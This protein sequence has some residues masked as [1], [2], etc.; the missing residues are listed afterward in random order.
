MESVEG[1]IV[2]Y[3]SDMDIELREAG[4]DISDQY[5]I[6]LDQARGYDLW[7]IAGSKIL[8]E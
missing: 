5:V 3:F 6:E 4:S 7:C 8:R 2:G 1:N